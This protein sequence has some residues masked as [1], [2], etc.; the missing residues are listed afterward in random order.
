MT[1]K[2]INSL[3]SL[4][5]V[6]FG[7][8]PLYNGRGDIEIFQNGDSYI[9]IYIRFFLCICIHILNES[10]CHYQRNERFLHFLKRLIVCNLRVK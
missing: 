7:V 4:D 6:R 3:A 5:K 9:Y 2:L 1:I 8:L 10:L